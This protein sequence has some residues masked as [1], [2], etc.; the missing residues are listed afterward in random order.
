MRSTYASPELVRFGAIEALT[1]SGI[2]CT[3]GLDSAV[4]AHT[5]TDF[6][7]DGTWVPPIGADDP[8][9]DNAAP[10]VR[11]CTNKGDLF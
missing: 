10:G 11:N 9:G 2:K 8:F 6:F 7:N 1:A 4:S 3:P 5:H